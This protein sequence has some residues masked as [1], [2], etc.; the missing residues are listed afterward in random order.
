MYVANVF[1]FNDIYNHSPTLPDNTHFGYKL[2]TADLARS[3]KDVNSTE[4]DVQMA[5]S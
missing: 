5:G 2:T 3:T 1:N 4:Q